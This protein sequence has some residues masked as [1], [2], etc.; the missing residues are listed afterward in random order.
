MPTVNS[1]AEICRLACD[2][3]KEA[4]I[5]SLADNTPVGRWMARNYIPA[6]NATLAKTPWSFAIARAVVTVDTTIPAFG[7]KY[8]YVL[9][10][11]NIR[12]LPLRTDGK[13][14]GNI[15]PFEN[16]GGY[17]LTDKPTS[18]NLR[19]IKEATDCSLY[20]P[21]FIDALAI[22]IALKA[23]QWLSGKGNYTQ[24]LAKQF[25]QIITA[26]MLINGAEGS[27]ASTTGSLYDDVRATIPYGSYGASSIR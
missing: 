7:W 22:N 11:D 18:I 2:L 6:R 8:R 13:I 16:E 23:S 5:V 24:S 10:R 27:T 4:A 25:E 26:A 14:N 3:L 21:M 1:D 17:I 19:Y 9:P 15:I 20:S 12:P